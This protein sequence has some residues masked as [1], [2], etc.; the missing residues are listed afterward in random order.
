VSD[1]TW[2]S[3][4]SCCDSMFVLVQQVPTHL[5]MLARGQPIHDQCWTPRS[6]NRSKELS[7]MKACEC[8]VQAGTEL[9]SVTHVSVGKDVGGVIYTALYA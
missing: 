9:L 1:Q 3:A 8:A 6:W 2:N 4:S 7:R 5:L